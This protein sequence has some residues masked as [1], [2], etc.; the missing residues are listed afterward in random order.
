[1]EI[2]ENKEIYINELIDLGTEP[3]E[4]IST[5]LITYDIS[6]EPPKGHFFLSLSDFID[7]EFFNELQQKVK[8]EPQPTPKDLLALKLR[9]MRLNRRKRH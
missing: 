4:T 8:E 1:M 7:I 6:N 2:L 9:E 3:K 5:D